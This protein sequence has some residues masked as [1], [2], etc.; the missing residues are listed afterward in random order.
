MSIDVLV[1]AG[2]ARSLIANRGDLIR[3][4]QAK[5]LRVAAAVPEEDYLPEVESLGIAVHRFRLGRTGTNPL[6]D[7]RMAWALRGLMRQLRPQVVF[8]YTVKPV[9]Y[10]S[11]A[12]R[13][14]GV[15]RAYSMITG[16]GH[17]YTT[18]SLKTRVLRAIISRLYRLGV[19]CS[20]KVF[21]QNPDDWADFERMGALPD[22][23]KA[24]LVNGS[25]VD[26]QRFAQQPLPEGGPVFT[27]IG[28]LLT[29]KG[30]AEFAEAAKLL[31]AD[32]PQARFVAVGPHDAALPHAVSAQALAQ[33]QAD[34]VVE[35]VGGVKDV[36]PYLAAC[37][38]FVLPSYREG[39]PRSV[40]EAMSV[41]RAIVTTDAP[42]CRETVVQGHNG[43]LVAPRSAGALA[44]GM[45]QFLL[46]P[47]L[48]APMAGVSRQLVE[49]KYE[50]GKVNALILQAM[51]L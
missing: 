23:S 50:V 37:S 17:A 3:A 42:G 13:L 27:F 11:L 21:F 20:R 46:R 31:R 45:R 35:F 25:G 14:A 49:E 47:E 39:T 26:V 43:F 51:E 24:V 44:E 6:A 15:P 28:R 10:G 9:I 2:N 40:L 48:V 32:Y 5:G 33:W 1:V 34:G 8:S 29:E 18:Q 22:A 30:I 36:R 19:A 12:A 7:L 4:M 38:V 16:M 41:G